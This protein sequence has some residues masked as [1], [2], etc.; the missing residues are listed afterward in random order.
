MSEPKPGFFERIIQVFSSEITGKLLTNLDKKLRA[1][2]T[3]IVQRIVK[4]L[5]VMVAG[6]II[7]LIGSM[8]LFVAFA[9]YL[10]EIL[11]STW[12]G[13]GV[14]GLVTLIVGLIIYALGRR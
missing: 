6:V 11:H 7:T 14:G 8:F 5:M 4:K 3:D 12:M 2:V 13:W 10:N 1:Y 9:K